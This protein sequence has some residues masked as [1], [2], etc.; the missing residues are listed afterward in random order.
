MLYLIKFL[1]SFLLPPGIFI[2]IL[3][4]AG[5]W[6]FRSQKRVAT[7]LL[8]VA[9]LIYGVSANITGEV[10]IHSL[11]KMYQPPKQPKGDVIVMLGGG[12]T[13][14]TTDIDGVGQLTGSSANR[15]LTVA[16][17]Y[18]ATKLPIIISGGKVFADTGNEA[19]IAKRQLMT[20]G[21]P[22]G[23]ILL[24]TRSLNTEQNAQY[25]RKIIHAHHFKMPIL[26]TSAFHMRRSVLQF[27]R[28]GLQVQPYPT[29]YHTSKKL[30]VYG[31][32]FSPGSLE[33]AHL[34]LKEYLGILPL[35]LK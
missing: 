4:F 11:E 29:D 27:E 18:Y 16:R 33:N 28:Q 24:D 2:L 7:L 23:K 17:M 21:I 19:Q 1:Y 32:Q 14:N 3:F 15:L 12:A 5:I 35:L 8:I 13:A 9:I 22:A 30:A 31:N 25:T 26:V 34:A 10:L 20:L 6:Y